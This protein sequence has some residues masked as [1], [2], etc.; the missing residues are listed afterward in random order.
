M[1]DKPQNKA[2]STDRFEDKALDK[3][4]TNPE[5]AKEF[6]TDA[7]GQQAIE[8]KRSN[9]HDGSAG[10]SDQGDLESV[11]I[12]SIDEHG[13]KK[14]A[15]R[16]DGGSEQDLLPA[17][18]S[19][20]RSTERSADRSSDRPAGGFD[21][22]HRADGGITLKGLIPGPGE[23][24]ENITTGTMEAMASENALVKNALEMRRQL[25]QHMELSPSSIP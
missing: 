14:V 7:K 21:E 3:P 25:D 4:L 9:K 23:E 5:L 13:N 12:E 10:K 8:H 16:K 19:T 6:Q 24:L 15:S 2:K 17:E 20:E 18:R 11:R 22:I 1:S